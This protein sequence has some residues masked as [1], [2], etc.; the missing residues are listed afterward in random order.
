MGSKD[1]LVH[2]CKILIINNNTSDVT[3]LAQDT[4]TASS[5]HKSESYS[6]NTL[7]KQCVCVGGGCVDLVQHIKS[8]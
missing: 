3:E 7:L 2:T 1:F 8:I 5:Q 6:K 4:I